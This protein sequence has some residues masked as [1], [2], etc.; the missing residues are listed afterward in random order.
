MV[1]TARDWVQA[2]FDIQDGKYLQSHSSHVK[3]LCLLCS[4]VSVPL[5]PDLPFLRHLE[6]AKS[7]SRHRMCGL[8]YLA[9]NRPAVDGGHE[10]VGVDNLNHAYDPRLKH[11]RL[12]AVCS[13]G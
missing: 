3:S 2:F 12:A 1:E 4:S 7:L 6:H 11:W 5:F 9:V 13:C 10:V 8:H